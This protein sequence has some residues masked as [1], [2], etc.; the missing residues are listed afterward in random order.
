TLQS[1][2]PPAIHGEGGVSR[3]SSGV[4]EASHYYSLPQLASTGTVTLEGRTYPV[5]GLTWMDHE[6]GSGRLAPSL[7][8]WD[9]F[10]LQLDDGRSLM[11]YVL[12]RK[13]GGVDS[14]SSGT[15]IE[16]DGRTRHLPLAA[17]ETRSAMTWKSPRTGATY[18]S[19]WTVRVPSAD[20]DLEVTPELADQELVTGGA[21]GVVYWE[22]AVRA[23]GRAGGK[24]IAGRGYVELTGYTGRTPGL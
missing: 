17:F 15:L 3:K 4:G 9:W 13:D 18:P 1:D 7:R 24:K 16:A 14:A 2:R 20:L 6:F 19:G 10:S 11:L 5:R 12:R 8:G 23:S 22:G 21:V